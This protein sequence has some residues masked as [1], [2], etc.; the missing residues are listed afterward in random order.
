[1]RAMTKMLLMAGV[2][3]IASDDTLK[4]LRATFDFERIGRDFAAERLAI[5]TGCDGLEVVDHLTAALTEAFPEY[6]RSSE[7]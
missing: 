3:A 7:V 4:K 5:A 6:R 1:M 2:G